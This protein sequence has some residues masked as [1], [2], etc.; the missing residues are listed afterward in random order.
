M[1]RVQGRKWTG[2]VKNGSKLGCFREGR[3]VNAVKNQIPRQWL[4]RFALA[5][6]DLSPLRGA[7]NKVRKVPSQAPLTLILSL[8]GLYR[9]PLSHRR[10]KPSLIAACRS[11][12]SEPNQ[13]MST[14][15]SLRWAAEKCFLLA[16]RTIFVE[17]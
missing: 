4:S 6:A 11:S 17:Q 7:I 16:F 5:L 8:S 2:K 15:G 12:S 1:T 14:R 9:T 3:E 10:P 13:M